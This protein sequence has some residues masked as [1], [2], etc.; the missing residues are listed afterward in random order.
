MATVLVT[1]ID[2]TDNLNVFGDEDMNSGSEQEKDFIVQ[3]LRSKKYVDYLKG[4]KCLK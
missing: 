3:M 1:E 4:L 2:D